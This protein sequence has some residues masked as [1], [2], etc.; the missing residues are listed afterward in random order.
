MEHDGK[1]NVKYHEN[2]ERYEKNSKKLSFKTIKNMLPFPFKEPGLKKKLDR[3]QVSLK[4]VGNK[5][6]GCPIQGVA[7][8]I[9]NY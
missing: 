3:K 2:K 4:C 8:K 5:I 6:F 7:I 1:L 9:K